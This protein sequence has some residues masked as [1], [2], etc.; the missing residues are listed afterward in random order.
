MWVVLFASCG[1]KQR[2]ERLDPSLPWQERRSATLE[3]MHGLWIL[4]RRSRSHSNASEAKVRHRGPYLPAF[5]AARRPAPDSSE[6]LESMFKSRLCPP[7]VTPPAPPKNGIFTAVRQALPEFPVASDFLRPASCEQA[8]T[9]SGYHRMHGHA[10]TIVITSEP[11]ITCNHHLPAS[12]HSAIAT[13]LFTV[14]SCMLGVAQTKISLGL[15]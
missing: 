7:R 2:I 5:S 4:I 1:S 3:V 15:H 12:L 14:P 10:N 9:S 6:V 13:I 11:G 8:S